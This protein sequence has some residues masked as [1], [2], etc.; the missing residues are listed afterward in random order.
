[1][2]KNIFGLFILSLV[3]FSCG[4]E[5]TIDPL[6]DD[7]TDQ[8]SALPEN[9]SISGIV[10]HAARQNL[11]LE[12]MTQQGVVKIAA[13]QLDEY[14]KFKLSG[15][16]PGL[17]IY[18]LRLGD[19]GD[20]LI[21]LTLLPDDKITMKASKESFISAPKLSG[22]TW[23]KAMTEYTPI[24]A[25][26]HK[27]QEELQRLKGKISDEELT[28]RFIAIKKPVDEFS[29]SV[30][31]SD[32]GNPYNIVLS[33][34]ITPQMGFESWDPANLD[35]LANVARAFEESYPGAKMTEAMAQQAAQVETMYNQHIGNVAMVGKN[36][37]EI[38]LPRP[39][40][41]QLTLSSL[42]GNYVLIDFWASW[43]GPCRRENPNVI[44]LYNMYKDKG[45]TVYSVSLDENKD[46]WL[47]AI[48]ADGLVWPNHVSDLSRWNSPIVQA[49]QI[50]G[51]PHTVLVDPKGK[52]INI[53]LRGAELEQKLNEIFSK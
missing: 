25:K 5:A 34:A 40:G 37:P 13:T 50:K 28:K 3:L 33:S 39:N 1:M 15:N 47:G 20:E 31:T 18:Q 7:A 8:E 46:A 52:I 19:Q 2:I 14:G 6:E 44:R 24:F 38:S 51:I 12:A 22:G 9:F 10:D 30:M 29:K 48:A 27:E 26:F 32:P 11:Y 41:S 42:R 49:Y 21:V 53:G 4:D 43:C 23:T 36:A 45:F 17:G 35:I 16:I